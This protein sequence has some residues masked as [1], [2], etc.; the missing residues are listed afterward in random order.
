MLRYILIILLFPPILTFAQWLPITAVEVN[1]GVN[2][3]RYYDFIRENEE[4]RSTYDYGR[5]Y[6]FSVGPRYK[7]ILDYDARAI[8]GIERVSGRFDI[9]DN[10]NPISEEAMGEISRTLITLEVDFLNLTFWKGLGINMGIQFNYL[11]REDTNGRYSKLLDNSGENSYYSLK[12][13]SNPF[14]NKLNLGVITRLEYQIKLEDQLFLCPHYIYLYNIL[15]VFDE[16]FQNTR[17]M[18]HYFGLG[19]MKKIN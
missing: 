5:G 8:L 16:N 4:Y 19:L 15:P 1:G 9:T 13:E 11:L 14:S 6:N 10:I 7:D 12:E 3:H 2:S 17:S 18:R